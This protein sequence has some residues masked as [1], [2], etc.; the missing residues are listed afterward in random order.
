MESLINMTQKL[1]LEAEDE[2][3]LIKS[4]LKADDYFDAKDF[5]R[6]LSNYFPDGK[7]DKPVEVTFKYIDPKSN[8]EYRG[9]YK[10]FDIGRVGFERF[11]QCEISFANSGGSTAWHYGSN[12]KN[13]VNKAVQ[14]MSVYMSDIVKQ[15]QDNI[16]A[17]SD[18]IKS[19]M[20]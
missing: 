8:N 3:G 16:E 17:R 13:G 5:E 4:N 10:L 19:N 12:D 6:Q 1:I 15:Y 18:L 14:D 9:K 2:Y 7:I 11:F 20:M